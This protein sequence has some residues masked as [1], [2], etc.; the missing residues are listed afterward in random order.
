MLVD[1]RD[2]DA[3]AFYEHHGFK[4]LTSHPRS[5]FLALGTARTILSTAKP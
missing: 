1:A 3:V 4:R 5:L 2:D